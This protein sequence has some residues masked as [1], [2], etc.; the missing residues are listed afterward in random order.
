MTYIYL[1]IYIYI[2]IYIYTL[3]IYIYTVYIYIIHVCWNKSCK[4]ILGEVFI[5]FIPTQ[6]G[7]SSRSIGLPAQRGTRTGQQHVH[8]I[9]ELSNEFVTE[10]KDLPPPPYMQVYRVAEPPPKPTIAQTTNY[11]IILQYNK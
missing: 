3:Y 9:Q 4:C 11:I 7:H 1:Y 10:N 8:I 6:F 5:Y 2:Y